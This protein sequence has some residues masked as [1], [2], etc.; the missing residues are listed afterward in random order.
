ME[1]VHLVVELTI[2]DGV[3]KGLILA[4]PLLVMCTTSYITG[5]KIG[6]NQRLMKKMHQTVDTGRRRL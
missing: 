5:S 4:I 2:T 3:K 1:Y 6:Q